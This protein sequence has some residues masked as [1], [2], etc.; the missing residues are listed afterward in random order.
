M[1]ERSKQQRSKDH[2]DRMITAEQCDSDSSES[3]VIRKAVV[4]TMTMTEHFVDSYHA[5]ERARHCH[6]ENDLFANRDAAVF[7]RKRI[8]ARRTDLVAPLRSPKE[9]INKQTA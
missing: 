6:R 4:V 5:R 2:T 3:V 9:K 1:L 8:A 7:C